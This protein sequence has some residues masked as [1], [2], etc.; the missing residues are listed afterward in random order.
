MD[1]QDCL[2]TKLAR[3]EVLSYD[4][5]RL[6]LHNYNSNDAM[7][8][9]VL[10]IERDGVAVAIENPSFI[11]SGIELSE[12]L[13]AAK[14]QVAAKLLSYHMCGSKFLN[15]VPVYSTAKAEIYGCSGEGAMMVGKFSE[16]FGSDFDTS[17]A[18][19]RSVLS[20]GL[21]LL[22]GFSF[23]LIETPEAFDVILP[24]IHVLYL[25]MLGADSHSLATSKGNLDAM[26][27]RLE[28]YSQQ[29]YTLV[30]SS[31][32]TPENG[33]DIR[34]KIDYL[35]C[36]D[37]QARA[38]NSAAELI[39]AMQNQYPTYQGEHFLAMTANALL[40]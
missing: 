27:A 34:K 22:C 13:Q 25:H 32:H 9:Q 40:G 24:D 5:G 21:N 8:D 6:R 18:P 23:E 15:S 26:I 39:E 14:I 16:A 30:C 31:H 36:L 4:F 38:A 28:V 1:K 29:N 12:Y 33:T 7:S 35:R 2:H 37:A 17:L 10:I 19:V 3:G 11:S 20:P